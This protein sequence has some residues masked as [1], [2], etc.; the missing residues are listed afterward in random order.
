[1]NQRVW[2]PIARLIR[3]PAGWWVVLLALPALAPL[4]RAAYFGSHDGLIH[5]YRL[6]ALDQAVRSGALYPRW[7]PDLAFGYGHPVLN[8]YGPLSYYL[9]LPFTLLGADAALATKLLLAGGLI[10]AGL[11]MYGFA[12]CHLGRGPALAAAVVYIYLPYHLVDLYVR[13]AIAE[14]LSFVWFPLL[15][16]AFYRLVAHPEAKALPQ[17]SLAALLLSALVLT[18]SLSAFLFVP[19]LAGYT[20]CLW[21]QRQARPGGRKGWQP[22]SRAALAGLLGLALSAF[23]WLPVLAESQ[24]VGLGSGRSQGYQDHLLSMAQVVSLDLVYPYPDQAGGHPTFPL[25]W[26]QLL[27][28]AASAVMLLLRRSG[29]PRLHLYFLAI[30]LGSAFMLTRASLPV[31]RALE[32]GLAFL[33]YPWRFQAVTALAAAVLAGAVWAGIRQ[34]L[35]SRP[36]ALAGFAAAGCGL[37]LAWSLWKLPLVPLQPDLSVEAMWQIDREHG[38]IGA[39]W[40]GEY[41][42]VWVQEQRWAISL[43]GTGPEPDKTTLAAGQIRLARAGHTRYEFD[44]DAR[45]EL[46]LTLHQFYYP[47]WEARWQGETHLAQPRGILGLA[48]MDLPAGSGPLAVRLALSP[49]QRGGTLL[50]LLVALAIGV[51][52]VAEYQLPGAGTSRRPL[53]LAAGYTLLA[54]ILLGGLAWP[55]GHSR[56][57]Q[58]V[59]ANLEDQ[60]E[61]LAFAADDTTYRP[62][63]TVRVTLYWL[64]LRQPAREYK[65]FVHLTDAAVT[66]QPAQHDGDP[67]EGFTPTS[68]WL[69]GEL[70]P[71]THPLR[72]P[73]DLSPGRYRLWAGMYEHETVRNLNVL[74]SETE[75]IDNRVLLGEIEVVAP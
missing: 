25:G 49:A 63:D 34:R 67:G 21:L 48:A 28:L 32:A 27:I 38:Q 53:S 8:F 50:S 16:W 22:L 74:S 1:M 70:I 5:L 60:A 33:Q 73:T 15:L 13:G 51:V 40:T 36:G 65:A 52:L 61:L 14:F 35:R 57:V 26:L 62:G 43:P 20:F 72:L 37:L 39:T 17:V 55:N 9:G 6:A 54:A 30:A 18:H 56:E 4:F 46:L 19:L 2:P 75:S 59:G 42:P 31:W 68:R 23:Y 66:R 41:L 69:A 64:A 7:F 29:Q 58:R 11:G 10:A 47:G 71:D 44:L 12:R 45:Q 24:H 3:V